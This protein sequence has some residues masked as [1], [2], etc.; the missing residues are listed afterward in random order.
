MAVEVTLHHD[1]PGVLITEYVEALTILAM[2]SGNQSSSINILIS[3]QVLDLAAD[4]TFT[5]HL[6]F[7]VSSSEFTRHISPAFNHER[8]ERSV[9]MRLY[10]MHKGQH[11]LIFI[12]FLCLFL[13]ALLMGMAGPRIIA[14]HYEKATTLKNPQHKNQTGV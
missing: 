9:Q 2:Y 10:T 1:L 8:P 4:I 14:Q 6:L 13:I 7:H 11:L 5:N 3:L 12:M